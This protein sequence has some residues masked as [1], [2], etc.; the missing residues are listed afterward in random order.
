MRVLALSDDGERRE[1]KIEDSWPHKGLLILKFS[2]VDDMNDA[3]T[4]V[5][6]ELQVPSAERAQLEPGWT[7]VSD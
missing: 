7:Y 6:C 1:L 2:G 5:G 3:E 4:I